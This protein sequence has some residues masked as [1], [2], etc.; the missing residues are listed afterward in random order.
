MVSSPVAGQETSGDAEVRIVARKLESGRI[1]F[2][3]QQRQ[4]DNTW[5]DRQLP[6]VRFFPTTA[7]VDRWLASSPLE[8]TVGQVRI[9]AR[10]IA[11]GRVEFGLQQRQLDNTWVER[12]LP[13]V[14]FFPTSARVNRW[15][16][17][18]PLSLTDRPPQ[19]AQETAQTSD[20]F[21]AVATG[22]FH[23]CGL[24][25]DGTVTCWGNNLEGQ[26]T[27]PDGHFT[28][29]TAGNDHTCGL[30]TNSTITCWGNNF[31]GEATAPDGHFTAIT[32]GNDHTCGLRT[33]STITCWGNNFYGEAT[34]PDGHFTAITA[35]N[36][37][38]CGLRTDNT[39]TCWGANWHG[40]ATA[41]DG[42][43]TAVTAG[44]AQTCGLRTD[45]TIECWGLQHSR[46][47]A[48]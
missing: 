29:I 14:R 36:D 32:A 41:P 12:R 22:I 21:S 35:G 46:V 34:A 13:R 17:S 6:R 16:A 5:S 11:D 39:I 31:Y 40:A 24:H 23:S 15:L 37:H 44:N 10:K 19:R 18:S 2:G 27:A 1:E 38:T 48:W 33:N 28:A 43:F 8:L 7:Q 3:L 26:A 25:A 9:V 4:T 47:A 42:H 30:R 45:G 20:G